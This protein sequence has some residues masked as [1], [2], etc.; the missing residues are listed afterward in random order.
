MGAQDLVSAALK[1]GQA[2]PPS[3]MR[4]LADAPLHQAHQSPRS[5]RSGGLSWRA[6]SRRRAAAS[7][8][9]R[10]GLGGLVWPC[11]KA[12]LTKSCARIA[13]LA[14]GGLRP[15]RLRGAPHCKG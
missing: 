6:K 11:F 9:R 5:R 7:A 14:A 10:M 15:S 12:A 8:Q 13:C 1:Q 3:P 2:K 4:R